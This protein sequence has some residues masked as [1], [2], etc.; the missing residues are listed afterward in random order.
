MG[1]E[2]TDALGRLVDCLA[3]EIEQRRLAV[4][5]TTDLGSPSSVGTSVGTSECS[6]GERNGFNFQPGEYAFIASGGYHRRLS[7]RLKA[8]LHSSGIRYQSD[9]SDPH[10]GDDAF[11]TSRSNKEAI[12]SCSVFVIILSKLSMSS[13][14][15]ADLLAFAEEREKPIVPIFVSTESINPAKMFTLANKKDD[16]HVFADRF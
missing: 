3:D 13:E 1:G 9:R 16:I 11:A 12:L 6:T 8:S 14:I 4:M 5:E 10:R 15:L 7:N 2:Y